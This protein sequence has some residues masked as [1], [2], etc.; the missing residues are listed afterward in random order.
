MTVLQILVAIFKVPNFDF[1][2]F[3]TNQCKKWTHPCISALQH[4]VYFSGKRMSTYEFHS[5]LVDVQAR[6]AKF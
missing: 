5:I 3:V 4:G 2:H 1:I 6:S